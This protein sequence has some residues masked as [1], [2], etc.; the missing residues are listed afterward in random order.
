[1]KLTRTGYRI[2]NNGKVITGVEQG[3]VVED[4]YVGNTFKRRGTYYFF[5][6]K[7]GDNYIYL[8]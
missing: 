1:M 6:R 7:Q 8:S 5:N 2:N 3:S 4:M